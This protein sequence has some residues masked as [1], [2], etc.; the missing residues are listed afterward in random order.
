MEPEILLAQLRALIER[1]PDWSEYSPGSREH[2][3]WL[4]QAHALVLRWNDMEAIQVKVA[5]DFLYDTNSRPRNVGAILGALHRAIADL[6]LKVPPNNEGSFAAGDVYDFFKT[7]NKVIAS[8]EKS[9]FI[10]DPYL[11]DTVFDHYLTSR[12]PDVTVRLMLNKKA[13]SLLPATQKYIAQHGPVLEA[14]KSK[15]IH[16]RVIFVDNYVCWVVGQS[17][18]DAAKAKPTYLNQ[19]P[20]DIV[21]AKLENYENIW[22]T[23]T[24]L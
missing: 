18:K 20:P 21:P 1:A 11:D 14:R 17:V 16:D 4:G 10:I 6:E 24:P 19:L 12:Q 3:T 23:A 15:A 13:N 9:I 7:L 22:A 5:S 8:A 2:Q